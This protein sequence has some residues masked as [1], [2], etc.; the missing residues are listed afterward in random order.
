MKP[1]DDHSW[2][3]LEIMEVVEIKWGKEIRAIEKITGIR[4]I[5]DEAVKRSRTNE[6]NRVTFQT[7]NNKQV[8][9]VTGCPLQP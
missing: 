5:E 1:N 6:A 2:P 7:C 4:A 3:L 8:T 9:I